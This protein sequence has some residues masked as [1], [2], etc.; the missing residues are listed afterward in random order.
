MLSSVHTVCG[1]TLPLRLAIV[2][3]FLAAFSDVSSDPA[4]FNFYLEIPEQAYIAP[5]PLKTYKF[6]IKIRSSSLKPIFT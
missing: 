6:S 4:V 2:P 5:H 1:R 3:V